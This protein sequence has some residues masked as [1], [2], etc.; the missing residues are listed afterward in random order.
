MAFQRP[1][2]NKL[3]PFSFAPEDGGRLNL[4]AFWTSS[5]RLWTMLDCDTGGCVPMVSG[6]TGDRETHDTR[7]DEGFRKESRDNK[8][9]LGHDGFFM[10]RFEFAIL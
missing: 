1:K 2:Q 7:H 4:L 8:L 3:C 6:F 9:K 5:I 10:R